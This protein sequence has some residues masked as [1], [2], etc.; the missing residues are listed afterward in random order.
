MCLLFAKLY[1][2]Q[3]VRAVLV[4]CTK[5]QCQL[6]VLMYLTHNNNKERRTKHPFSECMNCTKAQCRMDELRIQLDSR[7]MQNADSILEPRKADICI[8]P[9]PCMEVSSDPKGARDRTE[10]DHRR[11]SWIR[12]HSI[13]T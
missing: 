13:T 12:Q 4:N 11:A 10:G 9:G 5:E 1:S 3:Q 8:A 6:V 2:R 7:I